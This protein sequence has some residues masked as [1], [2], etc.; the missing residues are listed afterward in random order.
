MMFTTFSIDYLPNLT[1]F[2][3]IKTNLNSSKMSQKA[4]A[5]PTITKINQVGTYQDIFI[6]I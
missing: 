5:Y 2:Y 4:Y 6:I 3:N 1:K